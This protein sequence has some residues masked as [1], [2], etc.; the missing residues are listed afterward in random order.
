MRKCF[1]RKIWLSSSHLFC[2]PIRK[3]QLFHPK[4][5]PGRVFGVAIKIELSHQSLLIFDQ[6]SKNKKQ[7]N[8]NTEKFKIVTVK[9]LV[10]SCNMNFFFSLT[11][12]RSSKK[13]RS[14]AQSTTTIICI[15]NRRLMTQEKQDSSADTISVRSIGVLLLRKTPRITPTFQCS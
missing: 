6:S 15:V 10:H 9:S 14:C 1:N 12:T 5:S 13:E 3:L 11:G 8:K 4:E 2:H 7:K